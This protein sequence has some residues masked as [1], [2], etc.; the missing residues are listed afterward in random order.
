MKNKINILKNIVFLVSIFVYFYLVFIGRN[1]YIFSMNYL[2][3]IFLILLICL[4]LYIYG[5]VDNNKKTYQMN[6]NIYIILYFI[7]LISVTFIL[8]RTD[9]KFYNRWS[10]GQYKPFY[11]I[12]SQL[13]YGSSMEILKNILGNMVML[14]PLSFLL[15]VKSKKYNNIFR[16][17]LIILPTIIGIEIFQAF[18]Y[19]GTFDIDDIL[20]N[21]MGAIIFTFL[22]TRFSIINKIRTIFYTDYKL[23]NN[24]KI[25][26]FY[27]TIFLLIFYIFRLLF[28]K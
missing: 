19:V 6:I 20:L 5:I 23:K 18:T 14:I 24:L 16:Q 27:S 3:C 15:M 17:S 25:I 28:L 10:F 26:M 7:L 22:I 8:G 21:Y 13:H 1:Q 9:I 12:I 2:K 11:T 4:L